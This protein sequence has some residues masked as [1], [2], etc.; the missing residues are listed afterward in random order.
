[1]HFFK[2]QGLN[3]PAKTYVDERHSHIDINRFIGFYAMV[4]CVFNGK[5]RNVS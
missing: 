2:M 3:F 4:F 1:V 5:E